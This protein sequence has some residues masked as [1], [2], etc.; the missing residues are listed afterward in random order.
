MNAPYHINRAKLQEI[1]E[2]RRLTNRAIAEASGL[3]ADTVA[4]FVNGLRTGCTEQTA[5][6]LASAMD[7]QTS[8]FADRR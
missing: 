6:S 5:F 8:D 1:K 4:A 3:H 7:C 2:R